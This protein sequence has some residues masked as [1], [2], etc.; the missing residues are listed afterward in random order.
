MSRGEDHTKEER[1]A[2]TW[3]ERLEHFNEWFTRNFAG[4]PVIVVDPEQGA[5]VETW[6]GEQKVTD[7]VLGERE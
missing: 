4:S 6:T 2:W 3:E 5:T 7:L 1:A